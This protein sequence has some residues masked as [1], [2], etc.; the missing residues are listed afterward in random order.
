[1]TQYRAVNMA[2]GVGLAGALAALALFAGMV[3]WAMI[4]NWLLDE[5][6]AEGNELWAGISGADLFWPLYQH[7]IKQGW[8]WLS[9]WPK[10]IAWFITGGALWLA[11]QGAKWGYR[12]C[13]WD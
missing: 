12:R 7:W 5:W 13:L 4:V 11:Y 3:A 2:L 9:E 6:L 8:E 1:M 10:G